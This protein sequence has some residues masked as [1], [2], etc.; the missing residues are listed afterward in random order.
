MTVKTLV[1]TLFLARFAKQ[2]NYQMMNRCNLLDGGGLKCGKKK[3]KKLVS[4]FTEESQGR[5]SV[6]CKDFR[7]RLKRPLATKRSLT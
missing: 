5:F 2:R 6:F 4:N 7:T 1:R 3:I